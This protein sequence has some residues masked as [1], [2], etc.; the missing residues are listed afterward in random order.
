MRAFT[1][2]QIQR[3]SL[4]DYRRVFPNKSS[5]WRR[6]YPVSAKR[7]MRAI[8][9]ASKK[10]DWGTEEKRGVREFWYNPVKPIL[11]RAVGDRAH[12][13]IFYFEK[14]LSRM[15]KDGDLTY[16]DLGIRDFRTMRQVY[17]AIDQA[18][19]WSNVLLFVEKD[20]AYVH[21]VKMVALF[22]INIISGHGWSNTAGIERLLAQLVARGVKEVIVFTLTDYDPFGFAIDAEFI[23]KCRVL[24]LKII[25]HVR[26]GI[27]PEHATPEILDVQKYPVKQGRKL[28]VEGVSFNADEWLEQYGIQDK[29]GL[30]IEAISAQPGGA[31][32][33]RELVA[34]ELLKHLTEED[35]LAEIRRP[36]WEKAPD[37]AVNT[38]LGELPRPGYDPSKVEPPEEYL[39]EEDY[40]DRKAGIEEEKS[41][42]EDNKEDASS[43]LWLRV[44]AVQ[45]EISRITKPLT[46]KI[47][48]LHQEITQLE[49]P[50]EDELTERE[51]ELFFLEEEYR[52]SRA[53]LRQALI[54]WFNK[55]KDRWPKEDYDMGLPEG[56]ILKAVETSKSIHRFIGAADDSPLIEDIAK[57]MRE[58]IEKKELEEIIDELLQKN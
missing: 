58:A 20:S 12:K 13:Y 43:A 41:E 46:D 47:D 2:E 34:E 57:A 22:N 29:Y 32:T 48:E 21:L 42:I 44:S 11:L 49:E 1:L 5:R 30:E 28:T 25:T 9:L 55:N 17:E 52:K 50:Y 4:E 3:M 15:V 54:T 53:K 36:L 23:H 51:D 6:V 26:I 27:N 18:K 10:I 24:G 56:S 45:D 8:I 7:L 39:A 16:L 40:E 37:T 14:V 31:Q 33:L 38:V 35:R 19:C